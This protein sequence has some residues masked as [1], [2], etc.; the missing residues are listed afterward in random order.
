M[1]EPKEALPAKLVVRFLFRSHEVRMEALEE[2]CARFGP[3]DFLSAPL[4]FSYTTYYDRELGPGLVRQTCS[5]AG[6][7]QPDLLADIKLFTNGIE[8]RLSEQ[9]RRRIN[10]DPGILSEERLILA[11][12]KNFTHRVYLRDGIYAD[13]TLMFQKGAYQPFPWTYPDYRAEDFIK[14]LGTLREKLKLQRTGSLPR[15]CA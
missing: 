1:S 13:L 7:V 8:A 5:F 15:K 12:G 10:I 4:P 9:G 3:A 14:L 11:T 2:L 6:L